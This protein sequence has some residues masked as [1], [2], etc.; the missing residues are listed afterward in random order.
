MQ[1][2]YKNYKGENPLVVIE[3]KAVAAFTK[4]ID[5]EIAVAYHSFGRIIYWYNPTSEDNNVRNEI[6]ADAI[7]NITGYKLVPKGQTLISAGYRDWFVTAFNRPGFTI[8]ISPHLEKQS[9][10]YSIYS[11]VWKRNKSVGLLLANEGYQLW[12]NREENKN[13]FVSLREVATKLQMKVYWYADLD[14]IVIK[15]KDLFITIDL[16]TFITFTNDN[17]VSLKGKVKVLGG[18]IYIEINSLMQLL[19][20]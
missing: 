1:P 16:K 12:L 9:P 5:P 19:T 4:K 15:K 14:M 10:P 6:I 3:A 18:I 11:E 7:A 17:F 20:Y 13:V 8:E 2:S